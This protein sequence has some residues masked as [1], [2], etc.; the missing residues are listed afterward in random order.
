[1]STL[2]TPGDLSTPTLMANSCSSPTTQGADQ[3]RNDKLTCARST[4]IRRRHY[5]L[6][7]RCSIT[8]IRED[9][10]S[11]T[12]YLAAQ[13]APWSDIGGS[14][15][16]HFGHIV[17]SRHTPERRGWKDDLKGNFDV[18]K[19]TDFDPELGHP[20]EV[21]NIWHDDRYVKRTLLSLNPLRPDA[22]V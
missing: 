21:R 9:G 6:T 4:Q 20:G 17:T 16:L 5:T 18:T 19:T 22:V 12:T 3:M 8:S 14:Y 11:L 1:M 10:A 7:I 15:D 2:C 13:V